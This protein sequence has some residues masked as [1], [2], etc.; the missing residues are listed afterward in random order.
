MLRICT[1]SLAA[2]LLPAML[3]PAAL[4]AEL[5]PKFGDIDG[6]YYTDVSQDRDACR[7]AIGRKIYLC[8]QNTSFESNTKDRKYSGCLPIFRDQSRAC[9]AH[10]RRQTSKCDGS[11][12]TRI[13]DFTGFRCEVTATVVEEGGEPEG[14]PD[15]APTDRLMQA[16]TRTNVRSGPGTD[17]ARIG[18]LETGQKVR[19]TGEVGEWL[20][21][22]A[23]GGVAAFVHGSLLVEARPEGTESETRNRAQEKDST[24]AAGRAIEEKR[25]IARRAMD[26]AGARYSAARDRYSAARRELKNYRASLAARLLGHADLR[27]SHTGGKFAGCSA[28]LRLSDSVC[29]NRVNEYYRKSK[30]RH[31]SMRMESL[32]ANARKALLAYHSAQDRYYS[33]LKKR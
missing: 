17:R 16:R 30:S 20:R 22:E 1:V 13:T 6:I 2:V 32:K 25:E 10:F 19:V 7:Q 31:A 28:F 4:G 23:S 8:R 11:G 27:L 33:L 26:E 21:I 5:K 3:V 15:I 14:G 9:V 18:T 12:A 24:D 29:A